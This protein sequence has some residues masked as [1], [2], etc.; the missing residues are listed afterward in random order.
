M[1]VA[2]NFKGSQL[3][4]KVEYININFSCFFCG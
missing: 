1:I 3:S 2:L 4:Y